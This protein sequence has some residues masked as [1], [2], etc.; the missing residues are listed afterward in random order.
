MRHKK[1]KPSAEVN[2]GFQ[3]APMIDVVFV[4][5]LY[6]MV[7]AGAVQVENAHNTKLPGEIQLSNPDTVPPEEVSVR[8]EDDGQVYLNDDPV[9]S[10]ND[11][12]LPE[13][14]RSLM[15]IHQSNEASKT[16]V[17][18]TIYANE[19]ARY[20]RVIDVLDSL[21]QAKISDVTFQAAAPE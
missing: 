15:L 2:L 19:L 7:M 8:I 11:P 3:I 12:S 13:F 5:M 20:K 16:V 21:S 14:T 9:D 1:R 10:P 18:V 4:I 17:L 6:F